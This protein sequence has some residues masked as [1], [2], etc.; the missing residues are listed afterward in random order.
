M[1]TLALSLVTAMLEATCLTWWFI[2]PAMVKNSTVI[3]QGEVNKGERAS[4]CIT[5]LN[6]S[7]YLRLKVPWPDVPNSKLT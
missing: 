1:K 3:E 6:Y 5:S 2:F 7:V 4:Y